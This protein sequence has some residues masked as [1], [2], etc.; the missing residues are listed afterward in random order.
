MF[1][2]NDIFDTKHGG[3]AMIINYVNSRSI[4]VQ[5]L[6]DYRYSWGYLEGGECN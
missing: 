1:N 5:F 4:Q 3:K 6:D 2:N